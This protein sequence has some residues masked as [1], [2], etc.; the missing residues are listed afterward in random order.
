MPAGDHLINDAKARASN[1][2]D[3][4]PLPGMHKVRCEQCLFFF[5]T[6]STA[7]SRY[8]ADCTVLRRVPG[9]AVL[10]GEPPPDDE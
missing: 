9:E 8:C 1:A 2:T 10:I 7:P 5:A 4:Q 6:K 3:W